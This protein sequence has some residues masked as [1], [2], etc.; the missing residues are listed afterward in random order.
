MGESV[1]LG[2]AIGIGILAS[3][4]NISAGL[5]TATCSVLLYNWMAAITPPALSSLSIACAFSSVVAMCANAAYSVMN[6]ETTGTITARSLKLAM[7]YSDLLNP[8]NDK[9]GLIMA[10]VPQEHIQYPNNAYLLNSLGFENVSMQITFNSSTMEPREFTALMNEN[11]AGTKLYNHAIVANHVDGFSTVFIGGN[12]P[13]ELIEMIH[14]S[15]KTNN[16][17]LE[18]RDY[19]VD[20]ASYSFDNSNHDIATK[21]Y[22]DEDEFLLYERTDDGGVAWLG[23]HMDQKLCASLFDPGLHHQI[24]DENA[25]A[26]H[27]EIYWNAYGGIDS[28]CNDWDDDA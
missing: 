11:T 19:Y 6:Y 10:T 20:W 18:K 26:M 17:L 13:S 2:Y 27:G 15:N 28:F 14:S 22:N 12:T 8:I 7:L 9:T 5:A 21:W 24:D 23:Q 16:H 25:T 4:K 3:V 1:R